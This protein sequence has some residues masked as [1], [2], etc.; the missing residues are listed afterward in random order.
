M[1]TPY[2]TER[3]GKQYMYRSTSTYSA[4]KHGPVAVVEYMG[5]VIDGRL[6]PKRGYFYDE[7]TG[8]FGP[9]VVSVSKP[10]SIRSKRFG[11]AYFLDALQK[12]L[13]ILGDLNSSFGIDTGNMIMAVAFAY[14]IRPS[15]LMHMEGVIEK[16]CIPEVLG[17]PL[18]ADFS[19][20]R[21]SEL[22]KAIGSDKDGL[23]T[24]FSRR[25]SGCDGQ[26]VFDL[27]SEST[28]SSLNTMAE[29]G[30]N[31]DHMP[32]R[33]LNMGL[34]TDHEGRPLMFYIYPGSTADVSTLRRM[35]DDVV[36]LGGKD[37]TLV[38]DRGFVSPKSMWYLLD[39]GMDF[40][41][42]MR[43]DRSGIMKAVVT[44][45]LD[46]MGNVGNT[47]VHDGR[48]YCVIGR[49]IGV[50]RMRG[51]NL[52]ARETLWEDPDGYDLLLDGDEEFG[53]CDHYVDV[54]V[55]KDIAAAGIETSEMDVSLNAIMGKLNGT[56]ARDP[57]KH[58][59]NAAGIYAGMLKW[60]LDGDGR[61]VVSV[62]QN[63]H[64]FAANR[65]GVFAMVAPTRSN[66]DAAWILDAYGCRDAIEDVF[67]I[68]KS[69]GDGRVPRSGDR[70]AIVGRTFI[71]MVSAIMTVEIL[72]RRNEFAN[73]KNVNPK[74]KPRDLAKRT[75]GMFLDSLSNIEMIYGDGWKQMTEVTKDDRLI[76]DMFSIGPPKDVKWR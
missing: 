64:T 74:N 1:P 35:V 16:R 27:T 21:M 30:R 4:E 48:S 23:E 45:I 14:T 46:A 17:L 63:A 55:Y 70:E 49:S 8:E 22:T 69:E 57:K 34:V 13:G 51:A 53:S 58:F 40:V 76:F 56:K 47:L 44:S 72:R 59:E 6:K 9:V 66:R 37:A 39:N 15:A 18:D 31:K 10:S 20:Q 71:R 5:Q 2:I 73:D 65:K 33:Q 54:F 7:A 12:R 42:P 32:L 3:N 62:K 36:R 25:I 11:D 26:Y 19:S 60:D 61:M 68:D 24:F 28:Y 52:D 41:A 75:P 38:M 43:L 50:R 29:W 67:L